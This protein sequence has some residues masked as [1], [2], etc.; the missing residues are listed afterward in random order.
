LDFWTSLGVSGANVVFGDTSAVSDVGGSYVLVVPTT[1]P[2]EPR[3]DGVLM[4]Y[5]R[6]TGST[7][8]GDFLVR[9]GDCVTRYGTLADA[10]TRRPVFGATVSL[11][12]QTVMSEPGGWYR[13]DL[14][15]P[16]NGWF[17]FNTTFIYISHPNYVNL[18]QVVGR[19]VR[20]TMRL[21]FELQRR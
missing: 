17:G 18:E 12:G 21:D 8:R 6:V 7:Y 9:P 19:G 1:G 10:R 3:V 16:A 14:G 15:C 13:I 5:S 20:G 11:G 4:G 2:Y